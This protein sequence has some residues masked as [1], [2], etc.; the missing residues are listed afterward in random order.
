MARPPAPKDYEPQDRPLSKLNAR[1]AFLL[2]INELAPEKVK[3]LFDRCFES[4]LKLTRYIAST[5]PDGAEYTHAEYIPLDTLENDELELQTVLDYNPDFNGLGEVWNRLTDKRDFCERLKAWGTDCG[6][7]EKWFLE[8]G[9]QALLH[10][11]KETKPK[12]KTKA[13]IPP[14]IERP[15]GS[16]SKPLRATRPAMPMKGSAGQDDVA[17]LANLALPLMR[18]VRLV[19]ETKTQPS[20]WETLSRLTGGIITKWLWE[21]WQTSFKA[22]FD[23][24]GQR[25]AWRSAVWE[26]EQEKELRLTAPEQQFGN[27]Y[28][29]HRGFFG[30]GM[31][32]HRYVEKP[33]FLRLKPPQPSEYLP[34]IADWPHGYQYVITRKQYETV[35]K[36]RIDSHLEHGITKY[37]PPDVRKQWAKRT[38]EECKPKIDDY[39]RKYGEYL[40]SQGWVEVEPKKELERDAELTV[41]II[42]CRHRYEDIALEWWRKKTKHTRKPTPKEWKEEIKE[43]AEKAIRMAVKRFVELLDLPA[44][45]AYQPESKGIAREKK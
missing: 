24:K 31:G 39:W 37:V 22:E 21:F 32:A 9:W 38:F 42:I 18:A 29:L 12:D 16:L 30:I 25:A 3:D 28:E 43:G 17:P 19:E 5:L 10:Y 6:I 45:S 33:E 13:A 41:R 36:I 23:L 8:F 27:K 2:K 44:D 15:S 7:R 35:V 1:S 34:L 4:F 11:W 14:K 26:I 40:K 20:E